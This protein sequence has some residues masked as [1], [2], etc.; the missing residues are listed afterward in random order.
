M[1]RFIKHLES[2]GYKVKDGKA[3]LNSCSFKICTGYI[4]TAMGKQ[5][6]YWLELD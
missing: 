4:N 1:S 2:K 6:S 3:I 5:K